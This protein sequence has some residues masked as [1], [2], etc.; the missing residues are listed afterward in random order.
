MWHNVHWSH[1]LHSRAEDQARRGTVSNDVTIILTKSITPQENVRVESDVWCKNVPWV[2]GSRPTLS[3]RSY[4]TFLAWGSETPP[5]YHMVRPRLPLGLS[6][7][8]VP[9]CSEGGCGW[10]LHAP[11]SRTCPSACCRCSPEDSSARGRRSTRPGE[12]TEWHVRYNRFK[13]TFTH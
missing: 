4:S 5:C 7:W 10:A 6:A 3:L 12:Q 9:L 1:Y 13:T 8:T 11:S 2:R